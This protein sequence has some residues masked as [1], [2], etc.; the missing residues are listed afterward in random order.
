VFNTSTKIGEHGLAYMN[1]L[2]AK[3]S[4][5]DRAHLS[6]WSMNAQDDC[7]KAYPMIRAANFEEV[8]I[9]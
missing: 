3:S 2:R 1:G 9:D 4:V 8:M 7:K 5:A 6:A